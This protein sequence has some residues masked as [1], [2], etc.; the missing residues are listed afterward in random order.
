MTENSPSTS[1]RA[2]IA[3]T[4]AAA[5][6]LVSPEAA[7]AQ[8]NG[9][10]LRIGFIG[11]G[12][13][14]TF[15]A[16]I[17]KEDGGFEF[18]AAADY[19][20]D[21]LDTF[22]EAFGV[23]KE[24]R[25]TG[26]DGFKK[27]LAVD[28]LDAVAIHSPPYFHPIHLEEALKAGKHALVAKPVAIDVPGCERVRKLAE[29]AAGK[30]QVV[31]ADVQC[32]GDAIFNEAIRRVH[33]GGI[34][35]FCFGE[36][37]YEADVIPPQSEG[38]D[39]EARLR[40][41]VL[42]KDLGGDIITEQNIHALDI[43]SWALGQ[44]TAATGRSGRRVRTGTGDTADHYSVLFDFPTG[45]VNFLSRQ[46]TAWGAP[47]MC[48]NRFFGT[49]GMLSTAFGGKVMIRGSKDNYWAGGESKQLYKSGS[50]ENVKTFREQILAGKPDG[51]KTIPAAVQ[52]TLLTLLGKMAA[53]EK[54]TVTWA[55][56]LANSKPVTPDLKGLKA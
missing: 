38:G 39:A 25:F 27:L 17:V 32:R 22:G 15:V 6:A 36:C 18:A 34:G 16:N 2:F 46:Y 37:D 47:F 31:L 48:N 20:Q 11:C 43:V 23:P 8:A 26:L 29:V 21:K 45:S 1:R 54:R 24:A 33:E 9:R 28:K 56:F 14:G 10:K 50:V 7:L 40:N 51:N 49:K 4:S 41:W 5:V 19:F 3:G 53:D 30:G 55:D 12:G 13:R 35:D 42:W 52:T 44:P